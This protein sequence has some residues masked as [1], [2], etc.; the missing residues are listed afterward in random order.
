MKAEELKRMAAVML[1][2]AEGKEIQCRAKGL[3][4]AWVGALY[5]TWNWY[6][7]DYRVKPTVIKYRVALLKSPREDVP[8]PYAFTYAENE[9]DS[10]EKWEGFVKWAGDWKEVEV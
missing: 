5:P 3:S 8:T 2:A 10:P 1:A 7:Y 9:C 6:A 4:E